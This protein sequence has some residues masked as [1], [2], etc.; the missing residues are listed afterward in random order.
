MIIDN[1]RWMIFLF[2]FSR[3]FATKRNPIKS[4]YDDLK[5]DPNYENSH[6]FMQ[7]HLEDVYGDQA[8][9][10]LHGILRTTNR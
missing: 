3:L 9:F 5:W 6:G 7:S 1:N 10:P 8:V 2:L 4:V